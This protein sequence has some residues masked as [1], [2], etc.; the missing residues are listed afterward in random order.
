[1]I[2]SPY[3]LCKENLAKKA[4][5]A[6]NF[7]KQGCKMERLFCFKPRVRK[8]EQGLMHIE[9]LRVVTLGR[10]LREFS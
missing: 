4:D 8:R 5:L 10:A 3:S 2:V 7:M 6:H 9:T 1:M